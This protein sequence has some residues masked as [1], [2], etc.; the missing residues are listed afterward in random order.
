MRSHT[1]ELNALILEPDYYS[2]L[3]V[4]PEA[5]ASEIE[6]RFQEASQGFHLNSYSDDI[7]YDAAER[8]LVLT[9]AYELLS[10]PVERSHY[11]I[12]RFGRESLPLHE[13]VQ[14]Q[15]K[16]GLAAFRQHALDMALSHFKMAVKMYPHR[17]LFRVHLANIYHEKQWHPQA[18]SEL[19][20]ALRLD[21]EDRFAKETVARLIF[22]YQPFSRAEKDPFVKR[23]KT[24]MLTRLKTGNLTGDLSAEKAASKVSPEKP[25]V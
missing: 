18:A 2:R 25:E 16:S 20:I 5:L 3:G 19:E 14:S 15:F 13:A 12:R 9:Q 24:Q 22:D 21:P 4:H 23:F 6:S 11:D 8:L 7:R 10:H 1:G 17:G